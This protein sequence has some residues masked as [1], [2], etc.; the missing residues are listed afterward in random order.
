MLVVIVPFYW[1]INVVINAL[2]YLRIFEGTCGNIIL[3]V[4]ING[5]Q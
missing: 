3:S 5:F 2:S 1:A 4:Q